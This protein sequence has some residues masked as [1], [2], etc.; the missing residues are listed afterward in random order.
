MLPVVGECYLL[1]LSL[2]VRLPLPSFNLPW[3]CQ[4]RLRGHYNHHQKLMLCCYTITSCWPSAVHSLQYSKLILLPVGIQGKFWEMAIKLMWEAA[5]FFMAKLLYEVCYRKWVEIH[6]WEPSH[7]IISVGLI[8]PRPWK[9][10]SATME[11]VTCRFLLP[12]VVFTNSL[13]IQSSLIFFFIYSNEPLP[14]SFPI[15]LLFN[16]WAFHHFLI[17]A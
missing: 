17:I 12:R 15:P 13:E 9:Y 4:T 10:Y 14:Y 5:K 2:A 8:K 16:K 3:L 11:K 1:S 6:C 7:I